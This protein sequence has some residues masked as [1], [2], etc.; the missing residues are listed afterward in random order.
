MDVHNIILK[1]GDVVGIS[2]RTVNW[3][4]WFQVYLEY[5]A[6]EASSF[7]DGPDKDKAFRM[8]MDILTA[9]KGVSEAE[10][11]KKS[12]PQYDD[13]IEKS[14]AHP[15]REYHNLIMKSP[16]FLGINDF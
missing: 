1:S 10:K 14:F 12:I 7:Y 13:M 6:G 15:T 3:K 9:F 8:Y 2:V 16:K 4:P 11:F 5:G